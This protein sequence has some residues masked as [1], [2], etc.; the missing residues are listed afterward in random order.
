MRALV[1]SAVGPGHLELED[2]PIPRIGDD[3]VLMKVTFCGI[4]G[5]DLHIETGQHICFPPVI[6]GHEYTGVVAALGQNVTQFR[7]GDPVSF[8][9]G[10]Q[11]FPGYRGDG[12]FAE[13]MRAPASS[14][15]RTPEGISLE[16]AS[17]FETVRVP[18]TLVRDAMGMR[19]GSRVVVTGAGPIGLLTANAA[20]LEGASHVTVLG[21]P[22]DEKIRLPKALE[23]GADVAELLS[24]EALAKL[25]DAAPPAC[26]FETSG[27]APAIEAAVE[28][29]APGGRI[30]V[31]G[32]GRGPWN[33]NMA[34]VSFDNLRII[35][36]WGGN[37]RYLDDCVTLMRSGQLK[38]DAII[39]AVLPLTQWREAFAMLRRL[40]AIKVLLD[41]SR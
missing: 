34:R 28:H 25:D 37:N 5:S 36:Q 24:A 26:W 22:G 8:R 41:P 10:F 35:G 6:L 18:L 11:P 19:P 29:V 38:V 39:S 21:G 7:L 16:A 17:Q 27:A 32:L 3:D 20:K 1:K 33:V 12:A 14:L 23:L 9:T 2:V 4:C 31:S 13:Y 15:W 40:E 30:T